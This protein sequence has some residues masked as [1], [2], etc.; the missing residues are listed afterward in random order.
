MIVPVAIFGLFVAVGVYYRR[1]PD[2]HRP[3]MLMATLI[4]IPAAVARIG[5]FHALLY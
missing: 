2:A 1:R 4:A 5:P 3:M